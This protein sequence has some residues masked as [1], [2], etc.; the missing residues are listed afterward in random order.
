ML[1]LVDITF[2]VALEH[3]AG[4]A[5]AGRYTGLGEFDRTFEPISSSRKRMQ[6]HAH[7]GSSHA[8]TYGDANEC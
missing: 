8:L 5:L 3:G 7:C 1:L 2:D 4:D 6:T